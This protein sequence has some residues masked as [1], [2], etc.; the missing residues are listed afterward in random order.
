MQ[1]IAK[2]FLVVFITFIIIIAFILEIFIVI[3]N[4]I[5]LLQITHCYV[6]IRPPIL[7]GSNLQ[8]YSC[9]YPGSKMSVNSPHSL[10]Y[11]WMVFN[12]LNKTLIIDP[13]ITQSDSNFFVKHGPDETA[14]ELAMADVIIPSLNKILT[15]LLPTTAVHRSKIKNMWQKSAHFVVSQEGSMPWTTWLLML[16]F[17]LVTKR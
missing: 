3:I 2:I 9:C 11:N 1:K 15:T 10:L 13:S 14:R 7:C 4:S 8:K 16:S 17:G 5:I 12:Q 6:R